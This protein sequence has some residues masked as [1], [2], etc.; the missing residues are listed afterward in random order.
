MTGNQSSYYVP[1]SSAGGLEDSLLLVLVL[2]DLP[3]TAEDFESVVRWI[4]GV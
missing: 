1:V 3:T 2:G 4:K